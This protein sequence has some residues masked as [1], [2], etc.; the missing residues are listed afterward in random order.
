MILKKF[1]QVEGKKIEDEIEEEKRSV[2]AKLKLIPKKTTASGRS[3][4]NFVK[5]TRM[6]SRSQ[7]RDKIIADK[8]NTGTGSQTLTDQVSSKKESSAYKNVKTEV[9]NQLSDFI[10]EYLIDSKDLSVAKLMA[11]RSGMIINDIQICKLL[12]SSTNSKERYKLIQEF[13]TFDQTVQILV[14][15]LPQT[16]IL[17]TQQ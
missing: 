9:A 13:S 6:P 10:R 2:L 5:Q 11:N 3:L 12:D 8:N 16:G 15:P 14:E 7:K 4:N 17:T 1:R